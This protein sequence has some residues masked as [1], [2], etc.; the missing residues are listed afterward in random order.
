MDDTPAVDFHNTEW[1]H[2]SLGTV[3]NEVSTA[4]DSLTCRDDEASYD[5]ALDVIIPTDEDEVAE[6]EEEGEDD[7]DDVGSDDEYDG[8]RSV[9]DDYNYNDYNDND[10]DDGI[11]DRVDSDEPEIETEIM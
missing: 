10:D 5:P 1:N 9:E 6:E 7:D 4:D 3:V 2:S 8:G 11:C